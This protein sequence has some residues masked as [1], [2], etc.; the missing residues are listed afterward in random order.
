M[1]ERFDA[2]PHKMG[3]AGSGRSRTQPTS[4]YPTPRGELL[5]GVQ[6]TSSQAKS[7]AGRLVHG[8]GILYGVALHRKCHMLAVAGFVDPRCVRAGTIYRV[9]AASKPPVHRRNTPGVRP[10]ALGARPATNR[11]CE[12]PNRRTP[13]V[14][15]SGGRRRAADVRRS[16]GE[17]PL[18]ESG[19]RPRWHERR[20]RRAGPGAAGRLASR[21]SPRGSRRNPGS[22]G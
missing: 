3:G 17:A 18:T 7:S 8:A 5:G 6:A 15:P 20:H 16:T 12:Q 4:S 21:T 14:E 2:R 19:R 11:A 9:A 13:A 22:S 1:R 10:T